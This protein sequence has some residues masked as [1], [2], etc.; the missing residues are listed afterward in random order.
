MRIFLLIVLIIFSRLFYVDGGNVTVEPDTISEK[1]KVIGKTDALSGFGEQMLDLLTWQRGDKVLVIYPAGGYSS[2]TGLEAGIM[3][4][5][6]W[7]DNSDKDRPTGRPNTL[8]ATIQLSTNGMV[9]LRSELD[10]FPSAAWQIRLKAD[11]VKINDRLWLPSDFDSSDEGFKYESRRLGGAI[12][13]LYGISGKLNAGATLQIYDFTFRQWP[14]GLDLK[15]VDGSKGGLVFGMGPV[16]MFDSR[17]HILYPRRGNYMSC[18][19]VINAP[20]FGGDYQFQNYMVDLRNF[21]SLRNKV[22]ASQLLWEYAP[23]D[24]PFFMLPKLGGKERLRGIGHSQRIVNNSVWLVRSEL[25]FPLWW[26]FGAV[27]FAGLGQASE[28]PSFNC[29]EIVYSGGAGLRFRI[30]PDEPLNIRLD[31]GF[32]SHGLSGFFISLKEAF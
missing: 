5:F 10:W 9:E 12:Q 23:N 6:S 4:V 16:L 11:F 25:R 21:F 29:N 8:M 26:R 31:A 18:A 14:D 28:M 30:L 20:L 3:P 7:K 1:Q 17:D 24:V 15:S 13:L 22:V 19:A 32:A 2:R 27:A